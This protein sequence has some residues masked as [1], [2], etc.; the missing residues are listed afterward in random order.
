MKT[1]P[2]SETQHLPGSL[3]ASLWTQLRGLLQ[4]VSVHRRPRRLRL[5]ESLSLGEKRLIAVVEFDDQRFLV[6]ATP[7]NISL[8]QA[9]GPAGTGDARPVERP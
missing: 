8:L 5:A 4:G 9:L 1:L 7:E 3:M 2:L 6:A